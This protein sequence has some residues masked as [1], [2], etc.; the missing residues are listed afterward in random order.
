MKARQINRA[1]CL[2][3]DP[4]LMHRTLATA[5]AALKRFFFSATRGVEAAKVAP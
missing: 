5:A 2:N 1:T 3:N 4:S